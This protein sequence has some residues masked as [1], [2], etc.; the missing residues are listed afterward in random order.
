MMVKTSAEKNTGP[1]PGGHKAGR[2]PAGPGSTD[3]GAHNRESLQAL[4]AHVEEQCR[5]RCEQISSNAQAEAERVRQ[6]A[7]DRAAALLRE[8]RERERGNLDER[9]RLERA[10]QQSRIRQ[11]ELAER[12]AMADK[13]L[14]WV[15]AALVKLW[16][17]GD[18]A[19]A[20]WLESALADARAVLA[21]RR[22]Q[23]RHPE[24]WSPDAA[25]SRL[26][27]RAA[28]DIEVDWQPDSALTEGF[29]IGAGK[30]C[31]DAT[32]AGLTARSARIAGVLLA[33]LP[34]QDA[35]RQNPPVADTD[36]EVAS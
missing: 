6:A 27:E 23:L 35:R 30:A 17:D 9:L 8:V 32:P 13:G 4:L 28:P 15:R 21:G 22:W 7:R 20:R 19:R 29:V 12:R 5:A 1:D 14:A 3:I 25:A 24:A 31:V 2:D 16:S 33:Q 10:R 26:A 18:R 11:R 36:G 34:P